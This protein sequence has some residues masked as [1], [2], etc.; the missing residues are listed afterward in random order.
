MNHAGLTDSLSTE[1]SRDDGSGALRNLIASNAIAVCRSNI[2]GQIFEVNQAFCDLLGWNQSD[3]L[4]G[5]VRWTDITPPE[6]ADQ[7]KQ[8]VGNLLSIGKV[9]P[10]E[11]EYRHKNGHLIP[12]CVV[13]LAIDHLQGDDWLVF[14]LDI[15]EQKNAERQLKVSESQFRRLS[16][17]IPQIVWLTDTKQNLIYVNEKLSSFCGLT[18]AETAGVNWHKIIHAEDA[19]KFFDNWQKCS[20]YPDVY[21]VEIRY[22]RHDGEYCW[23]LVRAVPVT[24]AAKEVLMWIGTSTDINQQKHQ[25]EELIESELQYRMLADA[26]PQIVWTASGS[27]E[28]DFFNNRWFEYTG[29]TWEQSINDGWK[30]LIHPQD[31]PKYLKAWKIALETGDTYE[32]EFRLRRAIGIGMPSENRYRWHLGRAVSLQNEDGEIQKWFATWTEIEDQKNEAIETR[33]K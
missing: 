33:R 23:F 19:A 22:R 6:Y 9:G 30:L 16:E 28:I 27:G 7:S 25:Q 1:A 24:N 32:Q 29:L 13:I 20:S 17:S 21:E 8:A 12:V 26:I 4:S 15:S 10:F 3:V 14:I 18:R 5:K 31:R 11:K 2:A